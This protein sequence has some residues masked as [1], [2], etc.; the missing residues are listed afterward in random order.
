MSILDKIVAFNDVSFWHQNHKNNSN[1]KLCC[2]VDVAFFNSVGCFLTL[3]EVLPC[4]IMLIFK[5]QI[6]SESSFMGALTLIHNSSNFFYFCIFLR[7]GL[8]HEKMQYMIKLKANKSQ[9][10]STCSNFKPTSFQ[11]VKIGYVKTLVWFGLS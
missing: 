3:L 11:N 6:L 4:F 2:Y 7:T 8:S 1:F 10:W 5:Y 9:G